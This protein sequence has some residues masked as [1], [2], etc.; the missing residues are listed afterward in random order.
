MMLHAIHRCCPKEQLATVPSVFAS[1]LGSFGTMASMLEQLAS[2]APLSPAS[3]SHSVH[4]TTAG[5]FS[6]WAKNHRASTSISGG[7]DV[8]SH[9][10]LAAAAILQRNRQEPVLYV[11]GDEAMPE[12]FQEVSDTHQRGAYAVALLLSAGEEGERIEFRLDTVKPNKTGE[13]AQAAAKQHPDA[14]EFVRWLVSTREQLSIT[15]APLRWTW[16]RTGAVG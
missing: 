9:G 14:V 5:L 3:F 6:I 16:R 7:L 11:V 2:N 8:F 12:L 1:R 13:L 10:M 4:N 15:H